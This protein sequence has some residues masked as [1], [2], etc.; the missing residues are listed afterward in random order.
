M[1]T[2]PLSSTYQLAVSRAGFD[3]RIRVRDKQIDRVMFVDGTTS[4]SGQKS[5]G[6]SCFVNHVSGWFERYFRGEIP[7]ERLPVHMQGTLFQ[8]QVWSVLRRIPWGTTVSYGTIAEAIDQPGAARAVGQVCG[9]NPCPIVVPCHRVVRADGNLGGFR[10]GRSV[11][12]WLLELEDG[13][14]IEN[15]GGR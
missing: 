12:R 6:R 5:A 10:A 4:E 1:M 9:N 3:V 7:N 13:K 15:Q 14:N 11:K 8:R 2:D